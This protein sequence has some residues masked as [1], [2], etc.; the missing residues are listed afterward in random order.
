MAITTVMLVRD[1]EHDPNT[2]SPNTN[3]VLTPSTNQQKKGKKTKGTRTPKVS[4]SSDQGCEEIKIEDY[5]QNGCSE[6]FL[7]KMNI[8]KAEKAVL[9]K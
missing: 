2:V 9:R 6:C 8:S 3:D 4:T 1:S 5:F 7:R